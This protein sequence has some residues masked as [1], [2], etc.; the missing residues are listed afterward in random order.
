MQYHYHFRFH[1]KLLDSLKDYNTSLFSAD[2]FAGLTVGI[3]AL[4][5]AM[6]FAIAS[7]VPPQSGLITAIFA[8]FIISALGGTKLCIGGPTGA[9][10]VI[11]ATI[12][13]KY[14][15]TNLLICTVMAGVLLVLMGL[16]HLGQVIKFFPMPLITGFTNGIAVLIFLTQLKDFFGLSIEKMPSHFFPAIQTLWESRYTIHTPTML[17]ATGCLCLILL[18]PKKWGRILPAPFVALVLSAI[19]TLFLNQQGIAHFETIGSKFGGIPQQMPMPS[20]LAID[21]DHLSDLLSPALTIALLGA[22]E[23]LLC[24][25]VA[26]NLT[27]EKHDANQELIAQGIANMVVPFFGGIAATGAIARTATNIQNGGKTPFAGIIHA[28]ALL[29]VLLVAAPLASYIPM[30]GLAAILV[31]VAIKMGD[32]DIRKAKHYPKR[33]TAVLALTFALTVLFDLTVAV[34]IGLLLAGLFFVTR[35]SAQTSL[36]QLTPAHAK[37]FESQSIAGKTL[38]QGVNAYRV[39]GALFFG[40]AD[41]L[42]ELL[43]LAPEEVHTI[44]L[45]LHRIVLL[46]T[47][48]LLTLELLHHKLA[49]KHQRLMLCGANSAM[50]KLLEDAGLVDLLSAQNVQPDLA[51]AIEIAHEY[52]NTQPV[53][54]REII[55]T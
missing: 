36:N 6:A 13:A 28:L 47:T 33:D 46:D 21:W 7:G 10:I 50:H 1:P 49:A 30:A 24:A 2:L 23:S 11:L 4:P 17:L 45:Q 27:N 40:S 34:Q 26:D 5:L 29:L 43:H 38:P 41:K 9:Y 42:D 53:K 18:W 37:L 52:A 31:S 25:V 39:E 16:L 12:G 3:V 22:I 51:K 35:M 15:I 8:G 32:W 44:I 48:G 54:I 19:A 20:G 14:G 55:E